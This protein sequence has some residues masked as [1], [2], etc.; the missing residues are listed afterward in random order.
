[1]D[2]YAPVKVAITNVVN[3]AST[4][5]GY[6]GIF[7]AISLVA[8]GLVSV[9]LFKRGLRDVLNLITRN[10]KMVAENE[11]WNEYEARAKKSRRRRRF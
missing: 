9:E 11:A 6:T 1:M 3:A 10:S 7:M 2:P 8:L 5:F 4:Q